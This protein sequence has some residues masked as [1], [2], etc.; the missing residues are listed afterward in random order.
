MYALDFPDSWAR[1]PLFRTATWK[2][3]IA[4]RD[5]NFSA[6]GKPVLKIAE[7]KNGITAQTRHTQSTFDPSVLVTTGDVLF[8]W[9]GNPDTS[10]DVFRWQGPEG[11]LNQ[12]IFKVTPASGV[13]PEFLFYLLK[14][15]RPLFADIARTKQT[16]GLGHITVADLKEIEVGVPLSPIQTRI[17]H[18]LGTL[19]R[20]IDHNLE[21]SGTLASMASC[22][23]RR[24][25]DLNESGM[26]SRRVSE[27]ERAGVL[28]IGDGYRAKNTEL[29]LGEKGLPF[30][31]AA[32][33]NGG[34]NFRGAERLQ[35]TLIVKAGNKTSREYDAV[36]TSKGTVGRIAQVL[37]STPR[38]VY[39]PQLCFWRATDK[40]CLH[41]QVLFEWLNSFEFIQQ[42]DAVKGQTD[43][44]DYVS[45]RDQRDFEITLP[46]SAD[47]EDIG[48]KLEA[49]RY[50]IDSNFEENHSLEA[51]RNL[52]VPRIF[53][54]ELD[55]AALE[56][57][58]GAAA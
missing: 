34:F 14:Y 36:F 18:V 11:W 47:Q 25:C 30:A 24:W 16:I 44:A 43:M 13:N 35:E 56:I 42:V 29:T 15:L 58:P 38:F 51:I 41:P 55:I 54:G 57:S 4:F 2:N 48:R 12:H 33:L 40:V 19:D 45:L 21:M 31:R 27:L 50:R 28:E 1:R 39:S 8:S 5:I 52:L 6:S 32:N 46:W 53:S 23:F 37:P 9:S 20:K 26:E 49:L 17:A 22:L 3:G 7:L 10:I